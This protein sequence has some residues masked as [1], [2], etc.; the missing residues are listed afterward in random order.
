MRN[1]LTNLRRLRQQRVSRMRTRLLTRR[2]ITYSLLLCG[3]IVT[4]G[5]TGFWWLDPGVLTFSD[6]LWLAFTTAATVGYG[7][8]VPS[9]HA[10]RAFAVL[11]VLLGLGVLSL[12]TASI[13]AVFVERDVEAEERKIERDLMREIKALRAEV[14]SLRIEVLR[15]NAGDDGERDSRRT[16]SSLL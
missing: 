8:M 14:H 13:A 15:H 16:P 6:G 1:K 2:G 7:D 3:L 9:T 4:I 5:G 10:S 11:M 12:A